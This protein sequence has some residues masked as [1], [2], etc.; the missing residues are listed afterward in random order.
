MDPYRQA[1]SYDPINLSLTTVYCLRI[2][3]PYQLR[4]SILGRSLNRHTALK[5]VGHEDQ[6]RENKARVRAFIQPI[7]SSRSLILLSTA[8]IVC[9]AVALVLVADCLAIS[10][11]A[12][13][14]DARSFGLFN[15]ACA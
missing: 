1:G 10:S 11:A 6:S 7:G 15:S 9:C 4:F 5:C 14:S 13:T 12:A 3:K 2:A 8:S